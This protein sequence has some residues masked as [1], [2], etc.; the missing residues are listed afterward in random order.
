[1]LQGHTLVGR[2][3]IP[4]DD[5]VSLAEKAAESHL[6]VVPLKGGI[7]IGLCSIGFDNIVRATDILK[8]SW[9]SVVG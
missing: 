3:F 4:C 8:E 2:L 7:R 9:V 6:Y 5:P 1:M